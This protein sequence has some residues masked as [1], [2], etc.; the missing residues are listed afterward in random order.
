MIFIIMGYVFV[1]ITEY[2]ISFADFYKHKKAGHQKMNI[3]L[4][5][6]F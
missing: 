5:M 2:V 4:L 6:N 1:T 3:R